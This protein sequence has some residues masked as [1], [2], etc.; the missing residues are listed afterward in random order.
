MHNLDSECTGTSLRDFMR[1]SDLERVPEE[2]AK[3]YDGDAVPSG[4]VIFR[5]EMAQS[6]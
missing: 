4:E 5:P 1:A 6:K 2:I 3:M